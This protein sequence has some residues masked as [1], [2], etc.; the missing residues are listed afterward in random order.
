MHVERRWICLFPFA[1]PLVHSLEITVNSLGI[2]QAGIYFANRAV[3]TTVP[4][5]Q[6]TAVSVSQARPPTGAALVGVLGQQ[7][8][9]CPPE[10]AREGLLPWPEK[11]FLEVPSRAEVPPA[12]QKEHF[13]FPQGYL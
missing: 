5:A 3:L 9:L 11:P 7:M 1:H 13:H 4:A 12:A 6:G 8:H 10:K 2:S